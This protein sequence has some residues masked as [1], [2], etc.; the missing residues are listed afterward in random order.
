VCAGNGFNVKQLKRFIEEREQAGHPP[1]DNVLLAVTEKLLGIAK[2]FLASST[3]RREDKP[4]TVET[5]SKTSRALDCSREG[6]A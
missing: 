3:P 2:A 5:I 4:G 6:C 1:G